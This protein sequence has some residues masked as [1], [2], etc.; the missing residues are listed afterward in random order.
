MDD[1]ALQVFLTFVRFGL[2]AW[3]G[4][5]VIIGEMQREIV[6]L[7]WMSNQQFL[8][9][10]AIGQMSPGPGTLYVVPIGYQVAGVA[11]ALAA[12][13]GFF[14]P[15]GAIGL[16]FI[17]LWSR[18]RESRWPAAIRVAVTPVA[19]GLVLASVFAMGRS[20]VT[21]I[22]SMVIAGTSTLLFWR[23]A[24]PTPVVILGAGALGAVVF[25]R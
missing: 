22:P 20:S 4:G 10:Y 7:G 12:I 19:L 1:T 17:L 25:A 11:G 23:T 24:V 3:G 21:E 5:Q 2:L 9:A 8:E 13:L 15:S 6:A 18:V 14:L 16:I